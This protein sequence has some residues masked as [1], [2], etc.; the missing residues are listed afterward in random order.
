MPAGAHAS[1]PYW[2]VS[3]FCHRTHKDGETASLTLLIC[4][5]TFQSHI[6][7][8]T[9]LRCHE[10]NT[11][12]KKKEKKAVHAF[13]AVT[14][15]QSGSPLW[16]RCVTGYDGKGPTAASWPHGHL[17]VGPYARIR[18]PAIL[19]ENTVKEHIQRTSQYSY[20]LYS[21]RDPLPT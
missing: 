6:L 16:R 5:T 17:S 13:G 8:D 18:S 3:H 19:V 21:I 20:L 7:K 9:W 10:R 2:H 11:P 4:Y 14:A 12:R 1:V 15:Q